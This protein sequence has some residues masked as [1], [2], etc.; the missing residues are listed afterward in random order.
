MKDG[1]YVFDA[2]KWICVCYINLIKSHNCYHISLITFPSQCLP[3]NKK[4]LLNFVPKMKF[5]TFLYH[6]VAF[7]DYVI[8]DSCILS[9]NLN[10]IM[11]LKQFYDIATKLSSRK[12][13]YC[14]WWSTWLLIIHCADSKK[15]HYF[16]FSSY[17]YQC[18]WCTFGH[19]SQRNL[20]WN[21]TCISIWHAYCRVQ[22]MH[23][24]C[25][26]YHSCLSGLNT[27]LDVPFTV[28]L[29]DVLFECVGVFWSVRYI[30][31]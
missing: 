11:D 30:L 17:S 28:F 9:F 26:S 21:A 24:Y 22:L 4:M 6:K 2:K 29:L 31:T 19:K 15:Q 27:E 5:H 20:N 12:K 23:A 10:C 13:C 1:T 8:V 18:A 7:Y 16:S 3:C 14:F 25:R